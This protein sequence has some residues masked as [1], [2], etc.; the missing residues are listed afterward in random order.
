MTPWFL[1]NHIVE[2]LHPLQNVDVVHLAF[3]AH[4]P[5]P[6]CSFAAGELSLR[7]ARVSPWGTTE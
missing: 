1:L 7:S 4:Y 6:V 2:S 5:G 3:R